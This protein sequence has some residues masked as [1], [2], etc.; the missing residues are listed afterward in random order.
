MVPNTPLSDLKKLLKATPD[1]PKQGIIFQDI[2]PL[3]KNP[4]AVQSIVADI[5]NHIFRTLQKVDVIVG[6]DSRGFLL[7]PW[8]AA[9]IGA[10]F[11]PVRKPG[12]LPVKTY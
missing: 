1:F 6:L 2:F 3:F 8:I 5:T 9:T 7:G 4:S 10:A 12:K 11:V